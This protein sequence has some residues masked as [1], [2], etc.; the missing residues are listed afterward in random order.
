MEKAV[1]AQKSY[2]DKKTPGCAIYSW[3]FS[4][5]EYLELDA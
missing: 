4:I 3:G 2:Y 1:A 5:A